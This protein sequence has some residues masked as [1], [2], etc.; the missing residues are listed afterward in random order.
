MK[1]YDISGR[2]REGL[3][4]YSDQYPDY[5]AEHRS[6]VPGSCF[7]EVFRGFHSQSGTYLETT[8]HVNGYEG[9]RLLTDVPVS[10]LTDIPCRVFHLSRAAVSA[11]GNVITRAML[12]K[13]AQ[14]LDIPAGCALLFES[15]WD[16]WYSGSFLTEPPCLTREAMAYLISLD[17]C[18]IGSDTPAWQRTE[19]VFDLFAA[20]DKLLL[21]PLVGLGSV[22]ARG[23][24]TCLPV[25]VEGTCCA[26][27]RAI[28]KA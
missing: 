14:G 5:R 20:T 8:A 4:K 19:E 9:H 3:W 16:D 10:D 6:N 21:A 17:P 11:N 18:L 23:L 25:A 22:P 26:P 24:L 15:G 27:C 12:E 2:V 7:F 28:F 1:I 13:A